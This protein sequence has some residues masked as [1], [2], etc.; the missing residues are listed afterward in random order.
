MSPSNTTGLREVDK[1]AHSVTRNLAAEG[2][3]AVV[4]QRN[5]FKGSLGSQRWMLVT[6]LSHKRVEPRVVIV[7][8]VGAFVFLEE[9]ETV[10]KAYLLP[11]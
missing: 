10:V 11:V 5:E 6:E 4:F 9:L 7:R 2:K 8:P 1:H 3:T